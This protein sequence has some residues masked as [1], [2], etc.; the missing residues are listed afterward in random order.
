MIPDPRSHSLFRRSSR[1]CVRACLPARHGEVRQGLAWRRQGA[2][3]TLLISALRGGTA[4]QPCTCKLHAT[5]KV[6]ANLLA[7]AR[8]HKGTLLCPRGV[9]PGCRSDSQHG[10]RR[11][12]GGPIVNSSHCITVLHCIAGVVLMYA[13]LPRTPLPLAIIAS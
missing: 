1:A 7:R 2:G 4:H 8:M 10:R 6:P 9:L 3:H 12:P 5:L 11:S 13:L